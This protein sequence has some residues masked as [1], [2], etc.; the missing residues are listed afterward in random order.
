MAQGMT[1]AQLELQKKAKAKEAAR[2]AKM[3]PKPVPPPVAEPV[4][5]PLRSQ[6]PVATPQVTSGGR[7]VLRGPNPVAQGQQARRTARYQEDLQT[8]LMTPQPATAFDKQYAGKAPGSRVDIPAQD[9]IRQMKDFEQTR[10]KMAWEDRNRPRPA[11]ART[12]IPFASEGNQTL[13]PDLLVRPNAHKDY[14]SPL[15]YNEQTY[16][17]GAQTAVRA[18]AS[19][20]LI[21]DPKTGLPVSPE[22]LRQPSAG[23]N[24]P[25]ANAPVLEKPP[26][27]GVFNNSSK[28]P[29]QEEQWAAMPPQ[30]RMEILRDPKLAPQARPVASMEERYAAQ[31]MQPPKQQEPESFTGFLKD[32]WNRPAGS[33]QESAYASDQVPGVVKAGVRAI[34]TIGKVATRFTQE[35]VVPPLR[36]GASAV[37]NYGETGKFEADPALVAQYQTPVAQADLSKVPA[38]NAAFGDKLNPSLAPEQNS[39]TLLGRAPSPVRDAANASAATGDAIQSSGNNTAPG[40]RPIY[41]DGKGGFSDVNAPSSTLYTPGSGLR[42]SGVGTPAQAQGTPGNAAYMSRPE[43]GIYNPTGYDNAD[44]YGQS[45]GQGPGYMGPGGRASPI[46]AASQRG[47]AGDPLYRPQSFEE[48]PKNPNT[49]R[50]TFTINHAGPLHGMG[51]VSGAALH[52]MAEQKRAQLSAAA[53]GGGILRQIAGINR[54]ADRAYQK[55]IDAGMN[56]KVAQQTADGIRSQADQLVNIDKTQA[57]R[58]GNQLSADTYD[59]RTDVSAQLEAASIQAGSSAAGD[60]AF[61]EYVKGITSEFNPKTQKWEDNPNMAARV[62]DMM[63]SYRGSNRTRI[64]RDVWSMEKVLQSIRQDTGMDFNDITEVLDFTPGGIEIRAGEFKDMWKTS[65][66]D[67]EDFVSAVL[68]FGDSGRVIEGIK[69]GRNVRIPYNVIEDNAVTPRVFRSLR[70]EE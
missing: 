65:G 54:K 47:T 29:T 60:K 32:T 20:N 11:A 64:A 58:E 4:Q 50:G 42:S 6:Q 40:S 55:A 57:Q 19:S 27:V 45:N 70:G 43:Q 44:P 25:E 62:V 63:S 28:A 48:G 38:P 23:I 52:Q 37:N 59:R 51:P 21:R 2:L 34:D 31:G 10:P 3:P 15:P 66:Y 30:R 14:Q 18:A 16:Y 53:Q 41:S 8:E 69:N 1:T 9:Y 22:E 24:Y 33:L 17:P 26:Q 61:G 68:P 13:G 39:N 7:D 49:G 56:V 5:G 35:N 12:D 67:L 46:S 36:L